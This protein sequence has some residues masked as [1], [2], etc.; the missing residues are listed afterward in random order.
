MFRTKGNKDLNPFKYINQYCNVRMALIIEGIFISKTVVSLHIK[1]NEC[2]V[3][4]L[5]P[6]QS[7]LTIQESDDES[8]SDTET[9]EQSEVDNIEDLVISDKEQNE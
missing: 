2:Y 9:V 5:K 7:L 1:V 8:E 6:R 3:K 4:Q